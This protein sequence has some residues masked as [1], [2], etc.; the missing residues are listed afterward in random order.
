MRVSKEQA[1]RNRQTILDTAARLFRERGIAGVGV[2]DLMKEAGFTHGGFYNHFPS[3]EALAAEACGSAFNQALA[4]LVEELS[5]EKGRDS[6]ALARYLDHY[7]SPAHRD[8]PAGG[9]PTAALAVDAGRQ[10]APVQATYAAG[11]EALLEILVTH[12]P[13]MKSARK[14]TESAAARE[15]A[16]RTLSEMVGALVLSRAVADANPALSDEILEASRRSICQ[17]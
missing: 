15:Q 1:A 3:K 7:L 16:L 17:R 12:L 4:T 9:C 10:G 13:R 5:R 6:S 14:A 11:I 2:A 8:D